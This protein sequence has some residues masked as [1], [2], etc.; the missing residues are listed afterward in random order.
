M[1]LVMLVRKAQ[2][3]DEQAV[4]E[5]CERFTGLV[6]KYAYRP[7]VRLIAEEALSQGWLEVIQGIRQYDEKTGINFAGYIESRVMYGIWNLFKRERRRWENEAQLEGDGQDEDGLSTLEKLADHVD[8]AREV[9]EKWLYYELSRAVAALPDKQGKVIV[10][11]LLD[12]ESLTRVAA[13]LGITP[14]GV[15]N[16]RQRG[17]GGLKKACAGMYRDIRLM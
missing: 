10:R 17:I 8:V 16:L 6:K 11:T 5:I 7:H 14:Q 15:Y 2:E 13:E 1:E 3:G 4:C 9:E 12:G